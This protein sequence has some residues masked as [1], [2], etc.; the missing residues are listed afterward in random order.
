MT[1]GGN[2]LD[3]INIQILD[4]LSRD[5]SKSFVE[6]GK[7]L[8]ISDATVHLRVRR[9]VASGVIKKFT[10]SI[11]YSLAGYE[12]LAF[13]GVNVSGDA[14]DSVTSELSRH[15]EILEVH[16]LHGSFDFLLKIRS[17]SLRALR[18]LVVRIRALP[19][20]V[21]AELMPVLKSQKEES[22]IPLDNSAGLAD[23]MAG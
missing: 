22:T 2:H 14:A 21:D 3:E 23:S 16:E 6:I 1:A 9:L 4:I 15:A 20:V 8:G 19:H 17:Q 18:N 12:Q 13:L 7:Q 11:D 5:S 10:I